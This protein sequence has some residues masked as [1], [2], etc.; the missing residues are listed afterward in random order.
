MKPF[1]RFVILILV[2]AILNSCSKSPKCWGED[3]NKGIIV[4]DYSTRDFPMCIEAY[5]SEHQQ[6]II[7][8][9]EE[10][11]GIVDS[12]CVNIPEAG[13]STVPPDIDFNTNSL[14]GFWATGQCETKFIREVSA[15]ETDQK[16]VYEITV[17][18]CGTCK[19]ERYDPNL[20]LVPKLPD[21]Y[22]V[23]FTLRN[24]K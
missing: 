3:E 13:Y 18:E 6:M 7:T 8:S 21:G 23:D 16:Y 24:D 5:V 19:S 17:K 4:K 1:F 10:L 11:A 14:L 20:V 22:S 12:N 2:L 15:N 9:E